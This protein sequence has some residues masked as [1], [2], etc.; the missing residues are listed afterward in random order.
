VLASVRDISQ[1]RSMEE[2]L[3]ESETRLVE[4]YHNAS[5]AIWLADLEGQAIRLRGINPAAERALWV[6]SV[7][8]QGRELSEI[9][10]GQAAQGLRELA[11]RMAQEGRPAAGEL[12]LELPGGSRRWQVTL[13]PA[14]S[15]TGQVVR[16]AGFG[17]D[18]TGQRRAERE[19]KEQQE[20]HAAM[21]DTAPGLLLS[22][23]LGLGFRLGN[24]AF[25]RK[26]AEALGRPCAPGEPAPWPFAHPQPPQWRSRL[27]RALAGERSLVQVP[28]GE[29][30][31]PLPWVVDIAP[32]LRRGS[33]AGVTILAH[34]QGQAGDGPQEI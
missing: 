10:P 11:Q 29:G 19:L 24:S 26:F 25:Q 32:L 12:E 34:Q 17:R 9:F 21:I 27:E 13:V 14:R 8:T 7:T 28:A 2:A 15:A 3:R 33:I 22:L 20:A 30:E 1:R 31:A 5:D 16:F 23:D 4:V 6:S 18:V